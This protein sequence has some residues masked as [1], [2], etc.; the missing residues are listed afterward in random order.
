MNTIL[1]VY[2][3]NQVN[4]VRHDFHFDYINPDFGTG[5]YYYL[6]EALFHLT[7][8]DFPAIFWTPDNVIFTR[9]NDIAL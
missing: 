1:R 5:L 2:F 7:H 4:M 9:I 3:Q 8:K 6:F